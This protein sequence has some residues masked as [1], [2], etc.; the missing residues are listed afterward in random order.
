MKFGKPL[1]ILSQSINFIIFIYFTIVLIKANILDF[2]GLFISAI[3]ILASLVAGIV[4]TLEV[5][6]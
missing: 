3:G 6:K 4:S 5:K 2:T 1:S